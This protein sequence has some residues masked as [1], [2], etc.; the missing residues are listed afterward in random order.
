M[1]GPKMRLVPTVTLLNMDR[2]SVHV[3]NFFFCFLSFP[4]QVDTIFSRTFHVT[5]IVS[6]FKM[7]PINQHYGDKDQCTCMT[8]PLN[9]FITVYCNINHIW[10]QDAE[11]TAHVQINTGHDLN[12]SHTSWNR[13]V[14]CD[15][16]LSTLSISHAVCQESTCTAPGRFAKGGTGNFNMNL[17]NYTYHNLDTM[18]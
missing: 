7:L 3:K 8:L 11:N 16:S 18:S 15:G 9:T 10:P 13:L 6:F 2:F 1:L 12:Q 4:Q 17:K 14:L 5:F